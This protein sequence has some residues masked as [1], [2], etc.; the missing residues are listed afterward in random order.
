MLKTGLVVPDWYG[1]VRYMTIETTVQVGETSVQI[2]GL[3]CPDPEVVR[4]FRELDEGERAPRAEV[5]LR[6]GVIALNSAITA[7]QVHYVEKRF[8][9][10]KHQFDDGL[11]GFLGERGTLPS[12]VDAYFGPEGKV[13]RALDDA[14]GERGKLA[15][16]LDESLGPDGRLLKE[17]LDPGVPTSPLGR[18]RSDIM[19]ELKQLRERFAAEEKGLEDRA[20]MAAKGGDF[21]DEFDPMLRSV[22]EPFSDIVDRVGNVEGLLPGRKVGDYTSDLE[23]SPSMRIVFE[24]K[25]RE[26]VTIPSILKQAKEAR[27]NRKAGY[28]VALARNYGTFPREAGWF[29]EYNDDTLVVSL[30]AAGDDPRP[31]LLEIAYRWARLRVLA[32]GGTSVQV[33]IDAPSIRARVEAAGRLLERVAQIRGHLTRIRSAADDAGQEITTLQSGI[34]T[35]LDGIR[36]ELA[37]PGDAPE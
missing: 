22:A 3:E 16:R 8:S 19:D 11:N 24:A 20:K 34:R 21:E 28:A 6:V 15:N 17:M 10:L 25:F 4:Y 13:Q 9:E 7:E 18:L 32:K 12:L 1:W 37:K 14:F 2:L 31:E 23:G 26:H 27:E 36:S 30:G 35:E 33:G 29:H 5:A